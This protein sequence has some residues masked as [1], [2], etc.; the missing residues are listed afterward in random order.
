M[1]PGD[2]TSKTQFQGLMT[3]SAARSEYVKLRQTISPTHLCPKSPKVKNN[4]PHALTH[5]KNGTAD[6]QTRR[7]S[8]SRAT[9]RSRKPNL[10]GCRNC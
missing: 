10:P 2:K 5:L 6:R 9:R 4:I 3:D 8:N 7:E 1:S